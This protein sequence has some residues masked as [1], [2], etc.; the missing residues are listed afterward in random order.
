MTYY[1]NKEILQ[2]DSVVV[3]GCRR[4]GGPTEVGREAGLAAA[5]PGD[6][7]RRATL[8]DTPRTLLL[9]PAPSVLRAPPG[10]TP[11]TL[12]LAPAPSVLRA[13]PG[14]VPRSPSNK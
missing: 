7:P 3:V 13:P 12:L 11:R 2:P 14:D 9:V 8:G 4:D 5:P 1:M 6:T 10:D